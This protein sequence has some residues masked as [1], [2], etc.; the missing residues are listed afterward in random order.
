MKSTIFKISVL[1]MILQLSFSCDIDNPLFYWTDKYGENTR[2]ERTDQRKDSLKLILNDT[3]KIVELKTYYNAA[4][5]ISVRLDSVPNDSRCFPW[6][7]CVW[8]GNAVIAF[9]F[10][11]ENSKHSFILNTNPEFQTDTLLEGYKIKLIDLNIPEYGEI[12]PKKYIAKV[13]ISH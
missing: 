12:R 10:T 13:L 7:E 5:M 3:I 11:K 2:P 6:Q 9:T 4:N 1:M 8:I